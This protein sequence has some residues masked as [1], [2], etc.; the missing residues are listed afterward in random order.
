[1]SLIRTITLGM[2][3]ALTAGLAWA[4]PAAVTFTSHARV[5]GD[6]VTLLDLAADAGK[7]HP[8][9]RRALEAQVVMATPAMGGRGQIAASRIKALWTQ[10]H[11]EGVSVLIPP[12]VVVERATQTVSA[13]QLAD[14][15]REALIRRLGE[16]A[17]HADIRGVQTG[18]GYTL[19]AGRLSTRV[20]FMGDDLVGRVPA[21][22]DLIVDGKRLHRARVAG[23]VDLYAEVVVASRTLAR[24][25]IIG[26]D[27]VE[28]RRVNLGAAGKGLV[29]DPSRIVGMKTRGVITAGEPVD[30]RQLERT[31]LIKRGEVV[32]MIANAAGMKV[33][34]KGRAEQ[35]GYA[36]GRI[37]L[38]NLSTKREVWGRV[39]DSGTVLVEF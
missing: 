16:Q 37:R 11:L 18:R 5:S 27:D 12:S 35:N 1:M 10:A 15:Y 3:L 33:A 23:Q 25:Q 30:M 22:I 9:L 31:I 20:S 7:L 8:Q 26:I 34:A 28:L 21:S 13:Q 38:S 39:L 36:D 17:S 14:I 29:S 19:P 4:A 2:I 32:T 24:Q 6:R